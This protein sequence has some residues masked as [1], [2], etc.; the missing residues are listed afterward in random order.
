MPET[1]AHHADTAF[2]PKRLT[3]DEAAAILGVSDSWVYMLVQTERIRHFWTKG[4]VY[5]LPEPDGSIA[6]SDGKGMPS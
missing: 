4:R 3:A 1:I 6:V 2:H 5:I